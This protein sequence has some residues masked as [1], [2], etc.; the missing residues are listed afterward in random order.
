MAAGKT[1][2]GRAVA[3]I[4]AREFVD[5]DRVIIA[6]HGPVPAIF[7]ERGEGAFR[8]L[9]AEAVAASLQRGAVVALGGGAVLH[10]ETQELLRTATVVHVTVSEDAVAKRI[11]NDKRPLLADEGIAAWRRILADRQHIYEDLADVEADTSRRPM[12]LVAEEVAAWVLEHEHPGAGHPKEN[13][14]ARV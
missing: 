13:G 14:T 4:L 1:S 8:E 7:A 2:V 11:D 5:T 10:P 3:K 12:R 6:K 9:E